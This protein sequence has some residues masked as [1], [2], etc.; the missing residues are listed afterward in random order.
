M[1]PIALD[2]ADDVCLKL[3]D[4]IQ[5]GVLSKDRIMYK[6]LRDTVYCLID[7]NHQHDEEVVQFFNTI[8]HL[9]GESTVNFM[10]GPMFHGTGKGGIKKP[11][12]ANPNLGG[13]SKPTRQ[14]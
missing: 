9:G 7:P 6:Y 2:R 11:E 10:R 8:E 5:R 3:N 14:K 13:P 4:L 12:E 1:Y